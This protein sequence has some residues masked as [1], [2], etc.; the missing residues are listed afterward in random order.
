MDSYKHL[1]IEERERIFLLKA[2]GYALRKIAK[3][4]CRSPSTVSRELARSASS[5]RYC[6]TCAR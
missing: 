6:S 5:G 4:I 2:K 3:D 1:T